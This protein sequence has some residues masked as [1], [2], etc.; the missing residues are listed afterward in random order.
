MADPT[1]LDGLEDIVPPEELPLQQHTYFAE[2]EQVLNLIHTNIK[3]ERDLVAANDSEILAKL[4]YAYL[5][6][7][8]IS[9][10]YQAQPQ[11]MDGSLADLITPVMTEIREQHFSTKKIPTPY[12]YEFLV[13]LANT[14]GP[15]AIVKFFSHEVGDLEHLLA[16]LAAVERKGQYFWPARYIL[17]LWLSFVT[18]LPFDIKRLGD[19]IAFE[20]GI[21]NRILDVAKEFIRFAGKERDAAAML[22][23]R[24]VSRMDVAPTQVPLI[25]AWA[26][27]TLDGTPDV[28]QTTGVLQSLCCVLLYTDR[29]LLLPHA[30]SLVSFLRFADSPNVRPNALLRK[31]VVKYAARAGLVL[32]RNRIPKWRYNRGSR[33]LQAN[34]LRNGAQLSAAGGGG[35]S[36]SGQ[37]NDDGDDDVDVPEEVEEVIDVVLN[38]LRDRDTIVRWSAAKGVGRITARLPHEFATEII[39]S[40]LDLFNENVYP[41][42]TS[43]SGLDISGVSDNTWHGACLALAELARRGLLL[44]LHLPTAIRWLTLALAFDQRRGSHSVGS[45]VRDAACYVCWAFARAYAPAVMAPHVAQLAPVLVTTSLYDREVHVRRAA[46]AAFQENVGRQGIFPHGIDIVTAADFFIVGNRTTAAVV[47]GEVVAGFEEYRP[48]CVDYLVQHSMVHWDPAVRTVGA[49]AIGVVVRV[50]TTVFDKI[51]DQVLPTISSPDLIT[52]HGGMLFLADICLA[53][54][55]SVTPALT[56]AMVDRLTSIKPSFLTTFGAELTRAAA[57]RLIEVIGA[58]RRDLDWESRARLLPLLESTAER[59]EQPLHLAAAR[60]AHELVHPATGG[61]EIAAIVTRWLHAMR[62]GMHGFARQG[63]PPLIAAV[64]AQKSAPLSLV[65]NAISTALEHIT[66]IPKPQINA[67]AKTAAL[68]FIADTATVHV[69]NLPAE[70]LTRVLDTFVSALDDYTTTTHGDVG[71]W[72]RMQGMAGL[73]SVMSAAAALSV[74][75]PAPCVARAMVGCVHQALSKIDRVREAAGKALDSLFSVP[76]IQD[77][78]LDRAAIVAAFGTGQFDWV[79]PE[80][81][82]AAACSLLRTSAYR[83]AVVLGF[84]VL[85][86]GLT[87]SQVKAASQIFMDHLETLDDNGLSTVCDEIVAVLESNHRVERIVTPALNALDVLYANGC[88]M[89]AADGFHARVF[90]EVR[91]EI[92]KTKDVN[93]ILAAF[94]VLGGQ[95]GVSAACKLAV[96]YLAQQTC[97]TYPR[98]RKGAAEALINALPLYLQAREDLGE[99]LGPDCQAK[100][101]DIL[102]GVEW[103]AP[104]DELKEKRSEL[105]QLLDTPALPT[106]DSV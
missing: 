38:G 64:C 93:K 91:I 47:A 31:L 26:E 67:E 60:A 101:G 100:A 46:S 59:K 34:I 18:M 1:A 82:Y 62:P 36:A 90:A 44:P 96:R 29:A 81:V 73:A 63:F 19:S 28:F 102:S 24:L 14:R 99:P 11:L 83:N 69:A 37:E 50:D 54:P 10:K 77:A 32:L 56:T 70:M 103:T 88:F 84:L 71:S 76:A 2:A 21:V 65:S 72:V 45:H 20:R 80:V 105:Y 94:K 12:M 79:T 58:V 27:Q 75:V 42:A 41:S 13:T 74:P 53:A 86:G 61:D 3:L 57:L 43:P 89:Y 87:E 49:E 35:G 25:V 16:L 51:I 39:T 55:A 17:L 92:A 22:M 48:Y 30:T 5:P 9:F 106:S 68:A 104:V 52:R 6:M 33:S 15:K 7:I 23:G 85:I 4:Y 40:V 78:V 66:N 98:V 95:A 97:H 8:K